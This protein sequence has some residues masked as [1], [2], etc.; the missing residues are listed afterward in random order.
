MFSW[1]VRMAE[2][3]CSWA[4]AVASVAFMGNS[5]VGSGVLHILYR[6]L[7]Y[8]ASRFLSTGRYSP[9][10][11]AGTPDTSTATEPPAT[12]TPGR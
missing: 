2:S 10:A 11:P 1:V 4:A 12:P 3:V 6:C 8:L 7:T 9:L 5:L